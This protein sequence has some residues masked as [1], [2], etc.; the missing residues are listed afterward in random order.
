MLRSSVYLSILFV[1]PRYLAENLDW[2]EEQL[3]DDDDD[4]FIFDCPGTTSISVGVAWG[5]GQLLC[6][7]V[8]MT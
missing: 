1:Y 2:L 4:Y 6:K 3:G 5:R 8:F 7:R